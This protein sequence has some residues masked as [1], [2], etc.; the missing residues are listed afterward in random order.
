M[1]PVASI[2]QYLPFVVA[3]GAIVLVLGI[4]RIVIASSREDVRS[5]FEA[6]L[7][8]QVLR[9]VDALRAAKNATSPDA[10]FDGSLDPLVLAWIRKTGEAPTEMNIASSGTSRE[11]LEG[12]LD[13]LPKEQ[14]QQTGFVL[15][16]AYNPSDNPSD[17]QRVL[18]P[19]LYRRN[20][21][22]VEVLV[23][24]QKELDRLARIAAETLAPGMSVK[25][26][27]QPTAPVAYLFQIPE[28][29]LSANA[30][31]AGLW[32]LAIVGGLLCAG[33][34]GAGAWLFHRQRQQL[35]RER[36]FAAAVSHELKTPVAALKA[37]TENLE[38]GTVRSEK[39]QAEYLR[40]I[41][42]EAKRLE[43]VVG[44]VLHQVRMMQG[45]VHLTLRTQTINAAVL[46][47][48]GRW[49]ESTIE[50]DLDQLADVVAADQDALERILDNL[51]ENAR[52]YAPG[53]P[54]II[55]TKHNGAGA[56]ITVEDQGPGIPLADQRRVLEAWQRSAG[57]E[58]QPGLG[59]G[60][61]LVSGLVKAH[62]GT[63]T[64]E[65]VDPH[66]L[67]VV[68]KLPMGLDRYLTG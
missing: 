54:I 14:E 8:R 10:T 24:D 42:S 16:L 26:A 5:N 27:R 43:R 33:A 44:N 50:T 49:R 56:S 61:S 62:G 35:E 37:L 39:R 12:L 11:S 68:L 18:R 20:A 25:A 7:N 19:V 64:L 65:S 46:A 66:G 55:R 47:T 31:A 3:A 21:K 4:A 57:H 59:L 23:L 30:P 52:K 2:W 53:S 6:F 58:H 15:G 60:L 63:I 9:S 38:N 1:K 41:S 22:S 13:G 29:V 40:L 36:I 28:D 17:R 48:A 45:Q 51:L 32:S 34:L 67:R